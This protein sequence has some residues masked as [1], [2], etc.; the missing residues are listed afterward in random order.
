MMSMKTLIRSAKMLYSFK[1]SVNFFY[2][3]DWFLIIQAFM[4][5]MTY[6]L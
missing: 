3:C 6:Q 1:N 2:S 5:Q 4:N